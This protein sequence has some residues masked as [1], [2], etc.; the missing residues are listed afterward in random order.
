MQ[1]SYN[2]QR[3]CSPDKFEDLLMEIET[4]SLNDFSK[5]TQFSGRAGIWIWLLELHC[6]LLT[7][8]T[9]KQIKKSLGQSIGSWNIF[10]LQWYYF[11]NKRI[12]HRDAHKTCEIWL[13]ESQILMADREYS[14]TWQKNKKII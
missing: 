12:V 6:I 5:A 2:L 8:M 9:F 3:P 7:T 11:D 13:T 10:S 1:E 14:E 4:Q